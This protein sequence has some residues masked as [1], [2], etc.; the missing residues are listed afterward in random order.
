MFEETDFPVVCP[1]VY[2]VFNPG[3]IRDY[4][5]PHVKEGNYLHCPLA[6]KLAQGLN[7]VS[8]CE[9]IYRH[10]KKIGSIVK[11]FSEKS[12]EEQ[13]R[14]LK[15]TQRRVWIKMFGWTDENFDKN[16]ERRRKRLFRENASIQLELLS[17]LP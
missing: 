3:N 16:F 9:F 14:T 12:Y 8:K 7:G 13:K 15:E 6:G 4:F 11:E 1:D 10:W 17:S 2:I 5:C